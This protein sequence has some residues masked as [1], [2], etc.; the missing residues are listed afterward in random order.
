MRVYIKTDQENRVTARL[1]D[2]VKK[3]LEELGCGEMAEV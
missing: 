1:K 3:V 2:A